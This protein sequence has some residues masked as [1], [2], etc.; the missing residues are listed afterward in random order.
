VNR[1]LEFYPRNAIRNRN[2]EIRTKLRLACGARNAFPRLL[3]ASVYAP[4]AAGGLALRVRL[5]FSYGHETRADVCVS[6]WM[7]G[8]CVSYGRKQVPR[9]LKAVTVG[10]VMALSIGRDDCDLILF[11]DC[12]RL[13]FLE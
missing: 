9:K 6:V 10:A 11:R 7:A 4:V 8:K 13:R 3:E 5:L 2:L 12:Q 1:R